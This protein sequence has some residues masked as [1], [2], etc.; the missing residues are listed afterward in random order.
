MHKHKIRLM[1]FWYSQGQP[2]PEISLNY[3]IGLTN[4]TKLKLIQQLLNLKDSILI[5][6]MTY[7]RCKE[8]PTSKLDH[9]S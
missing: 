2:I 9:N 8:G 7:Q 6:K 3:Q 5:T 1:G 4:R